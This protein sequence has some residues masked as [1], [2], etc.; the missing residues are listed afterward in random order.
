[1]YSPEFGMKG[2]AAMQVTYP[3]TRC[4]FG[5]AVRD[6]TPPVGIYARNWG[7]AQHDAAEG[8]HRP[9]TATAAL[10]APL[11]D[12]AAQPLLALVALDHGWFQFQQDEHD[13]RHAITQ[14][15]GLAP[16]C[17]LLSLSHTHASASLNSQV[18]G[19]PGAELIRP[20]LDWLAE[21]IGNAILDARSALA[22]AWITYSYGR[23]ALAANRDLWD[24]AAQQFVCGFNP[25]APADDTLL[26]ARVTDDAGTVLATLVNY[27]CHP[28]TLAW[29]NRLLSPDFV[30]AARDVLEHAFGAPALFLQGA[31][32]EL[33]PRDGF[34]GDPTVADRN[35]R[36]LGYAAAAVLEGL[37][38]AGTR[39]VYSGIVAS[40][41]NIGTWQYQPCDETE[42][43]RAAMLEAQVVHAELR[44]KDAPTPVTGRTDA[45]T[46]AV[47][48]QEKAFRRR[49]IERVLGDEPIHRMPI[50][51]WR[52]GGATLIAV[53]NEP[54][55]LLQTELRRRMAGVPLLVLG[56]TNGCLGYLPPRDMYGSGLY[57]ERQ[58]PY[59]PGCLE[60][61][62]ETATR[63]LEELLRL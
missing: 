2:A 41:A 11:D 47:E 45:G 56:V 54:Y 12:T 33:G 53:P 59:A 50:Y 8:I 62:I 60:Q 28:T 31:S 22:P 25:D 30:G 61:T 57:Q 5:V 55:S 27:A 23:C 35:G 52:L 24:A 7:A 1:M 26:A 32:G 48:E 36:Q 37:P 49:L 9:C 14:R 29:E 13:L 34:V 38:P 42:V 20:H 10:V 6:V 16:E 44:R 43:Q 46:V 39:L 51:V 40:G 19:R 18:Q 63:A 21:Q 17:L 3:Y 58:S 15:A 4:H